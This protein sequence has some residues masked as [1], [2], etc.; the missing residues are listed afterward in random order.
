MVAAA[1]HQDITFLPSEGLQEAKVH[2]SI[3]CCESKRNME[4]GT[5]VRFDRC[6]LVRRLSDSWKQQ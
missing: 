5:Y 3:S 2:L 6:D 1:A 4:R